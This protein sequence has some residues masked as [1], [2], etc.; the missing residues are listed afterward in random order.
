[1]QVQAPASSGSQF[2]EE[3]PRNVHSKCALQM[4]QVFIKANE[5]HIKPSMVPDGV[6][7]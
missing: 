6:N 5:A 3:G 7:R 1:M 4:T 2:V